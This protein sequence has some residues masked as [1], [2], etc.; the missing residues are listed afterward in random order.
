MDAELRLIFLGKPQISRGDA[1][2]TG[3]VYNKA[4][5]L[6]A[7]LAVTRRPHSREALAGLL[8]GEMPDAAAKANLRKILS[9]LREVA[10]HALIIERQTVAFD[11]A[12][13]YWLDTED[14]EARLRGPAGISDAARLLSEKEV[15][16]LD[17]AVAL[18][19]G[20]FLDGFYVRSAPAFEEWVLSERERLRQM[21]LHAL[22]RVVGHYTA[23]GDYGRGLDYATRLLAMEPWHEEVHQQMMILLALSG[24]RSA[25][26]GQFETCRRLL[27]DELGAEPNQDTVDLYQ[28]IL[29]GE[30]SPPQRSATLP[31]DWPVEAT[32]FVGRA[33]ELARLTE[34]LAASG[35]HLVSVVGI[36]G[37]GKTRLALQAAAQLRAK[38]ADGVC[39]VPAAATMS[40]EAFSHAI[41]RALA[42]PTTGYRH[43][44]AQ[45]FEQLRD[46]ETLLV[47][48]GVEPHPGALDFLS[49]LLQ[50]APRT[51]VLVTAL[52]PLSVRG[53][54]VLPLYGLRVPETDDPD[55]V[56]RSDAAQL[57]MQA[58][59]RACGDCEL[60]GDQLQYIAQ[61]CRLVE[62]MP[63]GIELAAAWTRLLS[64]EEIAQEIERSFRFLGNGASD[65]SDRH[66]SLSAAFDHSWNRMADGERALFRR[67]SVFRGGFTRQAAEQVAGASLQTLAALLDRCL[68]QRTL[69]GRYHAHSL[70]GQYGRQKLAERPEE[71]AE[72][73]ERFCRFFTVFLQR[74]IAR[75]D[76]RPGNEYLSEIADEQANL[77]AAWQWA[78]AHSQQEAAPALAEPTTSERYIAAK[79]A[80]ES[81]RLMHEQVVQPG[82]SAARPERMN[83]GGR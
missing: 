76:D 54:W 15:R 1:P 41:I 8:W 57:F 43:A 78:L 62:G 60:A 6:L 79:Q 53:E 3:L 29:R 68:I 51:R 42:L 81:S 50:H 33:E 49:G 74:M 63:L 55:E 25:A 39:F 22:F 31:R 52:A 34:R 61:V 13:A 35:G 67:L 24:Q 64:C 69:A 27:A 32:P 40:A 4:L 18:Y 58:M 77:D 46:R 47:L 20:D 44:M 21:A 23:I 26:I 16:Q 56:S 30:I 48:D 80:L 59:R 71:E 9:A 72:T 66:H 37:A 19:R 70:L 65:P 82:L 45:L 28:R 17:A 5:A 11:T 14:F 2:L 7:Y 36:S 38:F 12:T 10:G 75:L 73:Y 83:R